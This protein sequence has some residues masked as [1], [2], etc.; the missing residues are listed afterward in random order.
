MYWEHT[1]FCDAAALCKGVNKLRSLALTSAPVKIKEEECNHNLLR[2]FEESKRYIS[3][4]KYQVLKRVKIS[5][6]KKLF[7]IFYVT[8]LVIDIHVETLVINK[9]SICV[10]IM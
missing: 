7:K 5:T 1:S 6:Y 10:V 4:V 8:N 2:L 3:N 9:F